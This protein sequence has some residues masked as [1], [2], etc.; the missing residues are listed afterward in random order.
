MRTCKDTGNGVMICLVGV[1]DLYDDPDHCKDYLNSKFAYRKHKAV[2][3]S[4]Q[5]RF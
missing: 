1:C 3:D 2:E 5:K 4:K